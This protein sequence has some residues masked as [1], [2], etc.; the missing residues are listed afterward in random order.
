MSVDV[1][2][3]LLCSCVLTECVAC[4]RYL[5]I[6]TLPALQE[7]LPDHIRQ[8]ALYARP[9]LENFY[10]KKQGSV[11]DWVLSIE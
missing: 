11:P 4:D 3:S 8:R 6:L 1:G 9:N 5:Q 10:E 7:K 2:S